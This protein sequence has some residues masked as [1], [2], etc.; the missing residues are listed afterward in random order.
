MGILYYVVSDQ[1]S[2]SSCGKIGSFMSQLVTV[3]TVGKGERNTV[4]SMIE[5]SAFDPLS[6][7]AAS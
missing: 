5:K 3:Q 1:T 6:L 2:L 4:L 7:S